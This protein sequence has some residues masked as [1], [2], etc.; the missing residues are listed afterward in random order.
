MLIITIS[1]N[2]TQLTMITNSMSLLE[3]RNPNMS[4]DEGVA[5]GVGED[6]AWYKRTLGVGFF[7]T[8]DNKAP[9]MVV[10]VSLKKI[11]F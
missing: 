3:K 7:H 2:N 1:T 4:V 11:I 5:S 8:C 10:F 9:R 6:L